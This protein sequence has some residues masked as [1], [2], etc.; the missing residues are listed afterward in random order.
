MFSSRLLCSPIGCFSVAISRLSI[1]AA[2]LLSPNALTCAQIHN[3]KDG[4]RGEQIGHD[5]FDCCRHIY[6]SIYSIQTLSFIA[7]KDRRSA[8]ICVVSGSVKG[9]EGISHTL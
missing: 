9:T 4:K 6:S 5:I 8:P 3:N 2:S 1:E 7:Q